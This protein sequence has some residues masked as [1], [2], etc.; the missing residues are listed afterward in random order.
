M[1]IQKFL[2]MIKKHFVNFVG[3]DI[4]GLQSFYAETEDGKREIAEKWTKDEKAKQKYTELKVKI[5]EDCYGGADSEKRFKKPNIQMW[6]ECV[7]HVDKPDQTILRLHFFD[8][9]CTSYGSYAAMWGAANA[10][11]L[12]VIGK[13]NSANKAYLKAKKNPPKEADRDWETK[14][15]RKMV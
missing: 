2:N 10:S 7:G 15:N 11:N 12:G 13:S 8:K 14:C 4:Y 6:V 3:D 9:A 1:S 5:M